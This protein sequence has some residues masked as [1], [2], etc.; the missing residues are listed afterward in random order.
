MQAPCS[1]RLWAADEEAEEPV[2]ELGK[3]VRVKRFAMKPMTVEDAIVEM[4]LLDHNFFLFHNAE[5]DIPQRGLP[6][7]RMGTT[8]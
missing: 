4:E 2:E 1:K 7:R 6:A 3:V 8:G 5:T